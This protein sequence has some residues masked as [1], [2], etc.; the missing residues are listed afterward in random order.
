MKIWIDI[1]DVSLS[2][3]MKILHKVAEISEFIEKVGGNMTIQFG[4]DY[5]EECSALSQLLKDAGLD[6]YVQ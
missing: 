3:G 4:H 2:E 6:S 1:E 5:Q